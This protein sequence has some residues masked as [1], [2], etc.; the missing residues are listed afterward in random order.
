MVTPRPSVRIDLRRGSLGAA[1]A[2][3]LALA[4]AVLATLAALFPGRFLVDDSPGTRVAA[5]MCAAVFAGP[6]LIFAAFWV[7]AW[8]HGHA[9]RAFRGVAGPTAVV[10]DERGLTIVSGRTEQIIGWDGLAGVGVVTATV[11]SPKARRS[12]QRYADLEVRTI[13]GDRLAAFRPVADTNVAGGDFVAG[14]PPAHLHRLR[15]PHPRFAGEIERV[16]RWYAAAKW[17]P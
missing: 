10:L 12:P 5:W 3:L 6:F 2:L 15:L 4:V 8:L 14:R 7:N 16:V 13:A 9:G 17:L 11:R 1:G